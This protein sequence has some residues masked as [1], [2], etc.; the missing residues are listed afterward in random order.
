MPVS[1]APAEGLARQVVALYEQAEAEMMRRLARA[2]DKGITQPHWAAEKLAQINAHERETRQLLADLEAK[3]RTGVETALTTAY[4]RGGLAAV[5]ELT[6]AGHHVEPLA[7]SRALEALTARTMEA[8][9]ATHGRILRSYSD[10]YREIVAKVG[11]DITAETASQVIAGTQ[12]GRQAMQAALS[13]FADQGVTGFV[14]GAGRGWN[15]ASYVEM[16]V[17]SN[18][19]QAMVQGA[20]DRFTGNGEDLVIVSDT[21]GSCPICADFEG[22]VLS[23]SGDTA[24]YVSVDEARAEGF[25]HPS[26]THSLSLYQPGITREPTPSVD[27][28]QN[29]Q[30][31][32]DSQ[33]LRYLERQVRTSK[34]LE[35]V[36]VTPEAKAK[37][38]A[39][40]G[41][42]RAKI[43]AHVADTT[44][45]RQP[46]RE[47]WGASKKDLAKLA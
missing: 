31:Y 18:A 35:A 34:R 16:A 20:L 45:R 30:M 43:R 33:K 32:A 6:A 29:A 2:L 8:L 22:E 46:W 12:T 38:A 11:R 9:S 10:A 17:R 40:L 15:L 39:R 37:A 28:E 7:G 41:D 47:S 44:A 1:P 42:Y 13:Q 23:I 19:G 27:P 36:A 21:P 25:Q 26:C 4:E 5:A 3:A 14:D 24:G